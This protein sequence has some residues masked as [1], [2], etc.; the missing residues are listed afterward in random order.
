MFISIKKHNQ[1]M[2]EQ[3]LYALA[4]EQTI[5]EQFKLINELYNCDPDELIEHQLSQ[6]TSRLKPIEYEEN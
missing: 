1:L 5:K 6:L 2:T 4:L 3:C